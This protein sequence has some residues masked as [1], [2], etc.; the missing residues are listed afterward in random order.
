[1]A[2]EIETIYPFNQSNIDAAP[3]VHGV[4][5]LYDDDGIIY[6]GRAAGEGVS[7]RTRFRDHKSGR[8]GSCTQNATR[9][10]REQSNLA[11]AREVE[12]LKWYKEKFG[13]LPRCND[14]GA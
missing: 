6:I 3:N 8:E 13:R 2:A 12:L 11:V 14:R 7:I 10:A 9:Y 4:Y 1:M 5:V